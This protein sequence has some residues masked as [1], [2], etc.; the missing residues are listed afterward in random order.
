[1]LPK[2]THY[3]STHIQSLCKNKKKMKK[4][5]HYE[6]P[7][8]EVERMQVSR[9]LLV[10]SKFNTGGGNE[11]IIPGD[12]PGEIDSKKYTFGEPSVWET[13]A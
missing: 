3:H 2:T 7:L 10:E 6:K 11:Q 13:D 12:P 9:S 1:M 5:K 4:K 8:I